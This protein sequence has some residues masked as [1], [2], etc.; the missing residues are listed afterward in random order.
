MSTRELLRIVKERGLSI[1]LRDGRP[2]LIRN[3][4]DAAV[5]DKLLAVLK[6]HRDRIIKD[7][8]R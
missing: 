1:E 2:V 4:K 8:S 7:L 5:T 6:I 3:G